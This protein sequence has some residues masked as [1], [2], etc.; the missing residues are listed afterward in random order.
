MELEAIC[1]EVARRMD[2]IVENTPQRHSSA[3]VF[4][5]EAK[6]KRIGRVGLG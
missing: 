6:E 1:G 4:V 5:S 3:L 2:E